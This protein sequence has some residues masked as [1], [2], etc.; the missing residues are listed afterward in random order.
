V[1]APTKPTKPAKAEPEPEPEALEPGQG[2]GINP[3]AGALTR[4]PDEADLYV[5]PSYPVDHDDED[6]EPS[7]RALRRR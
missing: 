6:D 7:T 4:E 1:T 2:S 3:L 5:G